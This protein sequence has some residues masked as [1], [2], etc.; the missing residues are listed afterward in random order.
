MSSLEEAEPTS[1]SPP[2]SEADHSGGAVKPI[3]G[4]IIATAV[5]YAGAEFLM[6]LTMAA[7]LAVIFSPIA[8]YL[9]RYIGR[10]ASCAL[11]V[12]ATVII[13]AGL[14]YFFADQLMDV[15]VRV[16]SQS[17]N[18]ANKIHRFESSTPGWLAHVE[19]GVRNVEQQLH[20][21][22]P[23][24]KPAP[25]VVQ[26]SG[27]IGGVEEVLK[28]AR[29]VL[30]DIAVGLLIIVLFF[31]FLYLRE[32]LRD[33][34][35]RLAA[36]VRITLAAEAMATAGGMVAHYLL[37]FALVNLAYGT[38]IAIVMW[39][40][41][42]PNPIFWGALAFLLR[43]I[44]YIGAT[45]SALL[46]TLVA[47][48]LYPGWGKTLE[49]F[50]AFVILDQASAEFV[51]PFLIGHGIG[52]SPLA[53][54]VSA[55]YWSWL[56]GMPG[57]LIA[58]PLTSCLKVAG[59][60]IPELN[61][62][63]LV[64]GENDES[65]DS[66]EY[67]RQLLEI[68]K[69]G[70]SELASSYCARNGLDATLDKVIIPAMQIMS[71]E[72]DQDHI[73][74]DSQ[75]F[76]V[77]TTETL[78][79]DLATRYRRPVKNPKIRILGACAPEEVHSLGLKIALEEFRQE[80]AET[81]FVGEGKSADEIRDFAMRYNLDVFCLSCTN[82][83][84]IPAACSLVR[85]I[86]SCAHPAKVLAGGRAAVAS[87]KDLLAAGCSQVA[88]SLEQARRSIRRSMTTRRAPS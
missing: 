83:D 7:I 76:I 82:T 25:K 26:S 22:K 81:A 38:S 86:G 28:P 10:L 27:G 52:M 14:G 54:L 40:I 55:M 48:A 13:I 20:K 84:Y 12:A 62:L 2:T 21:G 5:L 58:I 66:E 17:E 74:A 85:E 1:P 68:D 73:S 15:A 65:D 36:R 32:G 79:S 64:L 70:A 61:F 67:Y 51:E 57:L 46:P 45:V 78:V 50:A 6:P 9:H 53:L 16:S 42:L 71:A 31:F 77:D 41:G 75:A 87:E 8:S 19:H 11:V 35:V 49:V 44:P 60:Y 69:E 34:L 29:P 88:H 43:F 18:I 72:R 63:S 33:K 37:L 4:V 47:F 56:W 59:D 30:K 80:G 39:L 24:K 3:L 23:A